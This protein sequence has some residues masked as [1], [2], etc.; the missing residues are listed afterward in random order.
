MLAQIQHKQKHATSDILSNPQRS[1]ST[2]DEDVRV[3][4]DR[5]NHRNNTSFSLRLESVGLIDNCDDSRWDDMFKLLLEFKQKHGHFKITCGSGNANKKLIGWV[6]KRR[7]DYRD[8]KRT[9]G[10]KGDPERMKRLESI[11]LVDDITT[12]YENWRD[13]ASWYG[14]YN[15]LLEFKQ[16]HGHVKVPQR[17]DENPKLGRWVV[18][19][20]SNYRE[21]KR[22]NGQKGDP[23]RMKHLE[24]I[25]LVDDITTGYAKEGVN[26]I[27]YDMYNQLLE[28]KQKHGH[29]KVPQLYNENPKLGRWVGKRR[30]NYREYKRT[31]GQKGD[32][33][34]MKCLESIGLVD[35]ITTKVAKEG[36]KA[37]WY[38]MYN[39][40]LEFKQEHGHVK[41]P[42]RSNENPKLGRW[43]T[44]W[45]SVYR[46]YKRTNGEKGDPERMKRLESIGLVD[47]ILV[48]TQHDKM[49]NCANVKVSAPMIVSSMSPTRSSHTQTNTKEIPL[50]AGMKREEKNDDNSG[51]VNHTQADLDFLGSDLRGKGGFW[52]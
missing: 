29:V 37:I 28:F 45:R 52:V 21:Y 15:Q 46:E 16:K 27:W 48:R 36:N 35:D 2:I 6:Y 18:K 40:L 23:E 20:R 14:M 12:G 47:D 44:H 8:Y 1:S 38:D 30:S 26:E 51:G 41:V 13:N 34:Q 49:T 33:E 39:Q 31:N 9:N 19:R 3:E 24:S 4:D 43:V 7:R 11:G 32:P 25:G 42:Q 22:T 5:N 10:E 17:C 50:L